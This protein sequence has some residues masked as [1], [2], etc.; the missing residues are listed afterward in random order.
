[1]SRSRKSMKLRIR[2]VF[3]LIIAG[4][5]R[6]TYFLSKLNKYWLGWLLKRLRRPKRVTEFVCARRLRFLR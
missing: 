2:I 3:C 4:V 1:M 6:G 5:E